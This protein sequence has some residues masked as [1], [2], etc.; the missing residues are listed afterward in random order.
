MSHSFKRSWIFAQPIQWDSLNQSSLTSLACDV[1]SIYFN[2][3]SSSF[4]TIFEFDPC[5]VYRV[6]DIQRL[7]RVS[8]FEGNRVILEMGSLNR[9]R[10]CGTYKFVAVERKESTRSAIARS[11]AELSFSFLCYC[12]LWFDTK[13]RLY[14]YLS[15]PL[16]IAYHK[17]MPQLHV[18]R[19]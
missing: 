3:P 14:Q 17:R 7:I 8:Y 18:T 4:R 15:S 16:K 5:T 10:K 6:Y 1:I 2:I 9:I 19:Q 13:E 12:E 11:A